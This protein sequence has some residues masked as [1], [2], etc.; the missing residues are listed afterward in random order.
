MKIRKTLNGRLGRLI[1]LKNE[2]EL[3]GVLL[4]NNNYDESRRTKRVNPVRNTRKDD[5]T[6]ITTDLIG[7]KFFVRKLKKNRVET[8]LKNLKLFH[9]KET[10]FLDIVWQ[11]KDGKEENS[12]EIQKRLVFFKSL[13]RPKFQS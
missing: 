9:S 7:Q 10:E 8:C 5:N 12:P 13:V 6:L 11:L 1:E 3:L 4:E 2:K